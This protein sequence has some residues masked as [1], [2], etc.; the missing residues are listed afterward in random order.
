M[1]SIILSYC[2]RLA[3]FAVVEWWLLYRVSRKSIFCITLTVCRHCYNFWQE[4]SWMCWEAIGNNE[5]QM[6]CSEN[7]HHQLWR[8]LIE[9]QWRD[10]CHNDDVIQLG[11]LA[12]SVALQ[13]VEISDLCFVHFCCRIPSL[14]IFPTRCNQLNSNLANFKTTVEAE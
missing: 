3:I 9:Q 4:T 5:S 8:T 1:W 7:L 11:P 12:F 13:F 10:G 6:R 14:V 2:H